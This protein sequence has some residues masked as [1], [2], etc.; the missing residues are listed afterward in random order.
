MSFNVLFTTLYLILSVSFLLLFLPS[1]LRPSFPSPLLL[2]SP[3]P[4]LPP[5]P[6]SWSY[7]DFTLTYLFSNYG[8]WTGSIS[9]L[10]RRIVRRSPN[11]FLLRINQKLLG[12]KPSHLCF[13]KSCRWLWCILKFEDPYCIQLSTSTP[14]TRELFNFFLFCVKHSGISAFKKKRIPPLPQHKNLS[15]SSFLLLYVYLTSRPSE[16]VLYPSHAEKN[17]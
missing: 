10:S 17:K 3:P 12:W 5:S 1:S 13:H 16:L 7:Y 8:V 15:K 11:L 2:L 4:P 6:L 14:Y 9:I